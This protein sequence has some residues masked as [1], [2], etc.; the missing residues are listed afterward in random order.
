MQIF[1]GGNVDGKHGIYLRNRMW[2]LQYEKA[3]SFPKDPFTT[4][5]KD[6]AKNTKGSQKRTTV[7]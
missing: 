1:S 6:K 5:G 7:R 2:F 3:V 4:I